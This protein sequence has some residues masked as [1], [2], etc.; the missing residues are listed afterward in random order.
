MGALLLPLQSPGTGGGVALFLKREEQAS[1]VS[2]AQRVC[3][4][5]EGLQ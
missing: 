2:G 1:T 5:Q 4:E 3:H